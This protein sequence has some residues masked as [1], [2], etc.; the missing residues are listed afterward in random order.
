MKLASP[1]FKIL[2]PIG[3]I[4][5]GLVLSSLLKNNGPEAEKQEREVTLTRVEVVTAEQVNH[6]L[7]ISARGVVQARKSTQISAEVTGRVEVDKRLLVGQVF[8]K[9]AT[10]LTIDDANY[11]AAVSE[12]QSRL[13]QAR[14]D[15]TS[16]QARAAQAARDWKALG[17]GRA[18]DALVLRE[19]QL[20]AAK[21]REE[22]ASAA[23]E[24][25][26]LDLQRTKIL[27]PYD[28]RIVERRVDDGALANVGMTLLAIESADDYEVELPIP[29]NDYRHLR[30]GE[31]G[32][33]ADATY[34]LRARSLSSDAVWEG[35]DLRSQD[36]ID[37]ATR[38]ISV[39]AKV[40]AASREGDVR[41]FTGTFVDALIN[42]S[43][44]N[45]VYLVPREAFVTQT[46]ILIVGS[47]NDLIFRELEVLRYEQDI[48]VVRGGISAGDRVVIT[49][50]G[51]PV[52][53][54]KV[55]VVE[56]GDGE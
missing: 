29:L 56:G 7:Q 20:A 16:E 26:R 5:G 44:L 6:T 8:E 36:F 24:R 33:L 3:I 13:A 31:D 51:S 21:A 10:L 23:V 49:S 25:A 1:V 46:K 50:L 32:K 4:V 14:A 55:S 18:P 53:G 41:M 42:G 45:R 19:P 39:V 35:S 38:S 40:P 9:G 48:A 43:E 11:L 12:A 27:A 52:A 54:E 47:E 15:L 17:N 2:L 22:A 28:C 30:K 37:P 34:E